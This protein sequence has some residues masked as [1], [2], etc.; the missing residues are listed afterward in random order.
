MPE[1]TEQCLDEQMLAGPIPT[2]FSYTYIA[3]CNQGKIAFLQIADG[4]EIETTMALPHL[5]TPECLEEDCAVSEQAD[6][7]AGIQ[8]P[9]PK[10]TA[11]TTEEL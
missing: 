2:P 5:L 8:V 7:L 6:I 4:Q 3:T 11:T 10:W 1:P 9:H